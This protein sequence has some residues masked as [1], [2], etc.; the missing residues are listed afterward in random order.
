M[1]C[2]AMIREQDPE[3]HI[4]IPSEFGPVAAAFGQSFEQ[5]N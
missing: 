2:P 3:H 4:V 5:T 1:V